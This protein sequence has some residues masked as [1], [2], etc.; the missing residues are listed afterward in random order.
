[1]VRKKNGAEPPRD[2]R[3]A[4]Q[5]AGSFHQLA[6]PFLE[7]VG[8]GENAHERAA[9]DFGG[10]VASATSMALSLELYLKS[11]RAMLGMPIP[12]THDLWSLYK[13]LPTD[14][15][16]AISE[17]YDKRRNNKKKGEWTS[18][19]IQLSVGTFNQKQ[20]EEADAED[21]DKESPDYSL[22]K[23]LKRN[24]DAFLNWRYIYEK[25]S[26]SKI[27]RLQYDFFHLGLMATIVKELIQNSDPKNPNN[28]RK[29][30]A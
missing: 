6:M 28:L 25:G 22:N 16:R 23:L 20:K 30:D 13:S 19:Q 24:K 11:L 29:A 7:R 5:A 8:T 2:F 10:F 18:F 27:V 15:K 12:Q 21:D 1:M 17:P 9:R 26:H 14:V 4:F 3:M